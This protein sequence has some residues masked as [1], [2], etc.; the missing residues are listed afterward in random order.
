MAV[1]QNEAVGRVRAEALEKMLQPLG[2]PLPK[3]D[4]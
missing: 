2:A 1:A 4:E 3:K